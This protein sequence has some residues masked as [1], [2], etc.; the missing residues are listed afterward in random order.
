MPRTRVAALRV[1]LYAFVW[2]DVLLLRPWVMDHGAVPTNLYQPL[3]FGRLLPLP[4]PTPSVVRFIQVAL[5]VCSALALSG[6]RP[7]AAGWATFALY[8][9]WMFV[10]FSYGKVDHD[11]VAF[12]VA[13]A[14]LPTAG[15]A[16]WGDRTES[17][18]AGFA[19]RAIQVAVVATYFLSAF[20]KFRYG[21]FEWLNESTLARAIIRRG[22]FLSVP[23]LQHPMLLIAGQWAIVGFELLSPLL[24][25]RGVVGRASLGA[26]LVFHVITFASIGIAFWPH[27]ICLLAFF[28]LERAALPFASRSRPEEALPA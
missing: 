28:P 3:F 1:A 6:R 16:R 27:I 2:I 25:V 20:A 11:R 15:R 26:A 4:T 22:N 12:L 17:E 18:A 14:V 13:L 24:L 10:A 8:A 9:Q 5:L 21:G 23:L 7:R 19:I